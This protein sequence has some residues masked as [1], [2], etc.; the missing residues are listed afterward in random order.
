[1]YIQSTFYNI[2]PSRD[3]IMESIYNANTNI[4]NNKLYHYDIP[5]T[6]NVAILT[7]I[8]KKESEESEIAASIIICALYLL[9]NT[10][11]YTSRSTP[12]LSV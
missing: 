11:G 6:P 1:M 2:Y 4:Y 8:L 5:E 12:N 3:M 10:I 9:A 7:S